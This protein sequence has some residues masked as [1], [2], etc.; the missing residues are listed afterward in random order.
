M[1][2]QNANSVTVAPDTGKVLRGL[3]R[4]DLILAVQEQFMTPTARF[5]DILLPAIMFVEQ[6]TG[7]PTPACPP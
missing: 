2:V 7:R 4:D 1:L 5:A 6:D 3:G